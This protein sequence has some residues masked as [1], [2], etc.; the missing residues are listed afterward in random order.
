MKKE[1]NKPN[2]NI[3]I[4]QPE[5]M[6]LTSSC[7]EAHACEECYCSAVQCGG[8]YVCTGFKCSTYYDL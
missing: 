4:L 6:M 2:M 3:L 5:E 1:F 7:F 8:T